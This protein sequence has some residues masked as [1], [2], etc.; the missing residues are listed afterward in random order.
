MTTSMEVTILYGSSCIGKSTIMRLKSNNYD[1]VEMDDTV[2]WELDKSEWPTRCLAYLSERIAAN[3][4]RRAMVVT[5]GGLP[6]PD[7]PA[8]QAIAKRSQGVA[9]V[10]HVLEP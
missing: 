3:T 4:E 6:L 10:P 2:F 7:H 8:Y 5:C 9:Y 1:K